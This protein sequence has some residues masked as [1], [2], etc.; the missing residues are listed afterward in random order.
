MGVPG[1]CAAA[2]GAH[3]RGRPGRR[4]PPPGARRGPGGC[5]VRRARRQPGRG[6]PAAG[7]LAGR[8]CRCR[9]VCQGYYKWVWLCEMA[10]A[11]CSLV[12]SSRSCPKLLDCSSYFQASF[13]A[14]GAFFPGPRCHFR[15]A[16]A[17]AL[18]CPR[19]HLVAGLPCGPVLKTGRSG[20]PPP[21]QAPARAGPPCCE[22]MP[23]QDPALRQHAR[24]GR[25][26]V[27]PRPNWSGSSSGCR[28]PCQTH[29]HAPGACPPCAGLTSSCW[30]TLSGADPVRAA[31][32]EHLAQSQCFLLRSQTAWTGADGWCAPG[33]QASCLQMQPQELCWVLKLAMCSV[34][35][36][37]RSA[38]GRHCTRQPALCQLV[39]SSSSYAAWVSL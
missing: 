15:H 27:C 35:E 38:M 21:L 25:C 23:G 9:P 5:I 13:Q 24:D 32:H 20:V 8:A 34:A 29:L 16:A 33:N 6:R 3:R 26:R 37:H 10:V 28:L 17:P 30:P 18:G 14:R 4:R 11:A 1:A 22:R 39:T 36:H 12:L 31:S 2:C 19:L 7:R